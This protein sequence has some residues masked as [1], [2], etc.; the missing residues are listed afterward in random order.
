MLAQTENAIQNARQAI[1]FSEKM[2]QEAKAACKDAVFSVFLA[3]AALAFGTFQDAL[4]ANLDAQ[5]S[6][7]HA[8]NRVLVA[9][10]AKLVATSAA[11]K[12]VRMVDAEVRARS[13]LVALLF[14]L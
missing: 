4:F 9:E 13:L 6:V 8:K 11:Q 10:M 12:A 2:N 7:R 14:A 5:R 3:E 1:S